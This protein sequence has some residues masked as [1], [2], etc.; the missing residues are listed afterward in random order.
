ML[1]ALFLAV[2]TP[3]TFGD[4]KIDLPA[5]AVETQ[6]T[7]Q[8]KMWRAQ[9]TTTFAGGKT[10]VTQTVFVTECDFSARPLPEAGMLSV[11]ESNVRQRLGLKVMLLRR[12]DFSTGPGRSIALHGTGKMND[13]TKASRLADTAG[14]VSGK[15]LYEVI[16]LSDH[17]HHDAAVPALRNA[18][19][20]GA[21]AKGFPE[22]A[23]GDYSMKEAPF[24]ITAPYLHGVTA[25]DKQ[26]AFAEGY[27]ISGELKKSDERGFSLR[28][29]L[30][31]LKEGDQRSNEE[32]FRKFVTYNVTNLGDTP[33]KVENG[34]AEITV[35]Y[36]DIFE[37]P[38]IDRHIFL[39]KGE[40]V[41]CLTVSSAK[42]FAA[43]EE[44]ARANLK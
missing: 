9:A 5:T 34:R 28:V 24:T 23:E 10:M 19:I 26:G 37:Q 22:G 35:N 4:L 25:D 2:L 39:R 27:E 14:W 3:Q 1:A 21:S 38:S 18:T 12:S 13:A 43:V 29:Y 11:H 7:P 41:G 44:M 31:K 20:A 42:R 6:A 33:V 15:K 30:A 17:G 36:V 8:R 16:W 40:W 32:L